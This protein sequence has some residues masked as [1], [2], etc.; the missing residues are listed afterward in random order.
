MEEDE[1][2]RACSRNRGTDEYIKDFCGKVRRKEPVGRPIQRCENN[3]NMEIGWGRMGWIH[4]A[5]DR[6]QWR[7]L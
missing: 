1:M 3:I 2:G 5:E 6:D 7:L 4:L